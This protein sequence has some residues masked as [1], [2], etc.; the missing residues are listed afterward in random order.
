MID[1]DVL[2]GA[3]AVGKQHT[4]R[5]VVGSDTGSPLGAEART[6]V[7]A[8]TVECFEHVTGDS[9]VAE[10]FEF[11]V[12][13]TAG[14]VVEACTTQDYWYPRHNVASPAV[15]LP[16]SAQV[17]VLDMPPGT[18]GRRMDRLPVKSFQFLRVSSQRVERLSVP[19]WLLATPVT[20][21]VRTTTT[22]TITSTVA[23]PAAFAKAVYVSYTLYTDLALPSGLVLTRPALEAAEQQRPTT[24]IDLIGVCSE[25]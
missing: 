15:P 9:R 21:S 2:L 16:P 25:A 8:G 4:S 18:W 19:R 11:P 17:S 23:M 14:S 7:V 22:T 1:V 24:H 10:S 13:S 6:Q 5:S 12:I 3:E 20:V